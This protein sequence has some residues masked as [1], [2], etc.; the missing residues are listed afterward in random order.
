MNI[1]VWLLDPNHQ[2][3]LVLAD[4]N[5]D[6]D[7]CE[8]NPPKATKRCSSSG[9]F[10]TKHSCKSGSE[11]RRYNEWWESTYPRSSVIVTWKWL[12]CGTG[13]LGR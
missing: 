8:P 7:S 10:L 13:R 5:S 12:K 2:Q 11:V 3:F 1:S 4:S 6:S 9:L